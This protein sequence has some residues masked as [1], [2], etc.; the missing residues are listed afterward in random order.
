MAFDPTW[1]TLRY[2]FDSAARQAF[3]L[4]AA[5]TRSQA[6][7]HIVDIGAGLGANVRHLA[8]L[9][10]GS[11]RWTLV[12]TDPANLSL[13][14]PTLLAWA[15]SQGWPCHTEDRRLHIERDGGA[16]S[17]STLCASLLDLGAHLDL[18]RVDLVTANALFDLLT[19][20]QLDAFVHQLRHHRLPLLAT[21][22]YTSMRFAPPCPTD[23][24]WIRAYEAHMTRPQPHGCAMGPSCASQ[25][26][27]ALALVGHTLD[28]TSSPWHIPPSE[29]AMLALML[30]FMEGAVPQMLRDQ[31]EAQ[32]FSHWLAQRRRE[33]ETGRLEI[34]V[35]HSDVFALP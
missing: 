34:S 18:D 30:D 32:S 3:P 9:L 14:I 35:E 6:P 5:L 2:R 12:D 24:T 8:S 20:A 22:N 25:L 4:E 26:T 16:L 10:P 1:L 19:R 13:A 21:L 17:I 15:T 23:P 29:P 7:H 31:A 11:Q 28:L 33:A 27:E